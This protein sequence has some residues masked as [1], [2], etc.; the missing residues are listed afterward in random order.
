MP[1]YPHK[2]HPIIMS[3]IR[4]E[5]KAACELIN[6]GLWFCND[7]DRY[8]LRVGDCVQYF[9]YITANEPCRLIAK[10]IN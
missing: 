4:S 8:L 9:Q 2:Y 6:S 3:A 7:S 5:A 1:Y 10:M